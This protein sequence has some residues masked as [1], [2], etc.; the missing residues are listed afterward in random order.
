MIR[1]SRLSSIPIF[2]HQEHFWQGLF[3]RK[4]RLAR[5]KKFWEMRAALGSHFW[6]M[7]QIIESPER[8]PDHDLGILD[9]AQGLLERGEW[10]P[11]SWAAEQHLA[12]LF[13]SLLGWRIELRQDKAGNL[14]HLIEHFIIDDFF[15]FGLVTARWESEV[16]ADDQDDPWERFNFHIAE[17]GSEAEKRFLEEVLIPTLGY[18][19]LD[20]LRLQ[21]ELTS[22]GL[23]PRVF[24]GQRAD[25]ALETHRGIKLVIEVD[26]P[27]HQ[28]H[29]DRKRDEALKAQ[30]WQVW[31]VSVARLN[32]PITL[33]TELTRYLQNANGSNK[34]GF[35]PTSPA[36]RSSSLT[37]CIWGATVIAR[38]Q[39]LI[40]E[41]LRRG[42]IS[43]EKTSRIRVIEAETTIGEFAVTDLQDW[44]GRLAELHGIAD[45]PR[46]RYSTEQADLVVDISVLQPYKRPFAT[47][48]PL[49]WSRPANMTGSIPRRK[50]ASGM[51]CAAKPEKSLIE[52][53]VRDLFRKAEL[54]DGQYEILCR[55][56]G[57]RDVVGL[58]PTGGGKSLTYQLSGLLLGGL[59]LYVSPLKSLLQDQR[60]RLVELGIDLAQEVSSA[61]TLEQRRE[62]SLLFATG[63]VRF[64]LISPERFLIK[65]FR[66]D[67]NHFRASIGEVSQV[68]VDECHCVSEW[69]HEFRPSYLSLSRIAKE[70]TQRLGVSAPLV[71]LTGTASSIVL[72]DVQRELGILGSEAIIRA[73]KL[74]REE[75]ALRCYKLPQNNKDE[76]LDELVR[77]FM[78]QKIQEAEG[79]LIFCRFIGGYEGVLAVAANML[80]QV[81]ANQLRFYCGEEPDWT[82]YA[83]FYYHRKAH[84]L[85]RDQ[86]DQCKPMWALLPEET[87]ASWDLIKADTQR[88]YI[89]GLPRSF[90]VLVATTAFGMGI[91]K[92]SIRSVIHYMT[93]QSPEAYY[94]EVGRAG[95]DRQPAEAILL[96]SDESPDIVDRI[97]SP[98]LNIHQVRE[99]YKAFRAQNRWGGGDFVK[100][101]YFHL[102]TFSG[103]DNDARNIRLVLQKIRKTIE[104]DGTPVLSYSPSV[105][106]R[107][108][109]AITDEHV[110]EYAVVR[111]FHLGVINDYTKDY[112]AKTLELKINEKWLACKDDWNDYSQY[113]VRHFRDYVGKYQIKPETPSEEAILAAKTIGDLEYAAAQALTAYIYDKIER[114]R[115]QA[116]RQMLE[117]ARLGFRDPQ[118]FREAL[119]MYLQVSEKFTKDLEAL[120][121]VEDILAWTN[122]VRVDS[123]DEINELHGACQRVL[124]SYPMHPGLLAI[125]SIT[126]LQPSQ[127]GLAR[128]EEELKAALQ[129]AS[130]SYGVASA[131]QHGDAIMEYCTEM[132]DHLADRLQSVYGVW[133]IMHGFQDEAFERFL[134]KKS[135]RDY[136][137][138][139]LLNQVRSS[140]PSTRGV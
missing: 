51:Y 16:A 45:P 36:P 122:I 20:F 93:P 119:L 111:L 74:D 81:P 121:L 59:T 23:E 82:K 92:P 34:W 4:I 102:T 71:A 129:Y 86:I 26:G 39:F 43:W 138:G 47:D 58:L 113:L 127:D 41:A 98:E 72:A 38:V 21:R 60:D 11:P 61:L 112:N 42:I 118:G 31:R 97:L 135:V 124:E 87:R 62:A 54:R 44:F 56:L 70:R 107:S 12:T 75:I 2:L 100:T 7:G 132:D 85:T 19:L 67:L 66:Q 140:L 17:K 103:A 13:A 65:S 48:T 79:L 46:F 28:P 128:S 110:L 114:K 123:R 108:S 8:L 1:L 117:F 137:L 136:W 32:D 69:G 53:F 78:A 52:S 104:V 76:R 68:V 131:K 125:S 5:E 33:R 120:I 94:Q 63:G 88:C 24:E 115:R 15:K 6:D 90:R 130:Q 96:F 64:L 25:F 80:K 139:N 50:F 95:R 134:E 109:S 18:P 105:E 35:Q 10:V 9:I 55:I 89:S 40:L 83:V 116:S 99:V 91:D 3:D 77:Q 126:R 37:T 133:L 22:L 29:L 30:G 57:G 106:E 101:F 14:G 49:A 73:K 27:F 84:E